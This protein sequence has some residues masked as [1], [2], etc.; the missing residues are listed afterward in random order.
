MVDCASLAIAHCLAVPHEGVAPVI[1]R[2]YVAESCASNW[3][4]D[5]GLIPL[6][7]LTILLY[8]IAESPTLG[9]EAHCC[10]TRNVTAFGDKLHKADQRCATA[11]AKLLM[12]AC[13]PWNLVTL[14]QGQV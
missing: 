9:T 10:H 3:H 6:P 1:T 14:A 7:I 8:K 4:P 5:G 2:E 12:L 11:V 13:L